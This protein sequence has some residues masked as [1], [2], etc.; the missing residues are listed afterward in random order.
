MGRHGHFFVA[1]FPR[2]FRYLGIKLDLFAAGL[3]KD[4]KASLD[5][6]S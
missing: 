2:V 3:I 4:V 5:S 6:L 1:A